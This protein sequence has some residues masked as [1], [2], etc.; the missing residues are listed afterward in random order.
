MLKKQKKVVRGALIRNLQVLQK[1]Q[2]ST[3]ISF[4]SLKHGKIHYQR[5]RIEPLKKIYVTSQVVAAV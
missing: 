1:L 5:L 3:G 2:L 4:V